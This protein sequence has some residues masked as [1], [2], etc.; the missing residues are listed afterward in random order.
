[1]WL[2]LLPLSLLAGYR[3]GRARGR[4]RGRVVRGNAWLLLVSLPVFLASS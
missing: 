1:L 2:V 3:F 4:A